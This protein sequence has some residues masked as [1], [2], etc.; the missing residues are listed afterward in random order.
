MWCKAM[1][2]FQV[3]LI[4]IFFIIFVIFF[5]ISLCFGSFR[6]ESYPRFTAVRRHT[7][8]G[9]QN[10]VRQHQRRI[11]DGVRLVWK[12]RSR[13][14][15]DPQ[16]SKPIG[17]EHCVTKPIMTMPHSKEGALNE[18]EG[19]GNTAPRRRHVASC[20][21]KKIQKPAKPVKAENETDTEYQERLLEWDDLYTASFEE[22]KIRD[23]HQRLKFRILGR[24]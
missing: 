23:Y 24:L 13:P 14:A 22:M 19:G 5:L 20:T 6:F 4:G 16:K 11:S 15:F 7:R 9:T 21:F 18:G 12:P 1:V 2:I 8:I 17:R 3:G 10:G